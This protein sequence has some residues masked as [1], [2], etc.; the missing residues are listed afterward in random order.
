M[1]FIFAI[2]GAAA[3]VA[4]QASTI[5]PVQVP[6]NTPVQGTAKIAA[7]GVR[8]SPLTT[9]L[10]SDLTKATENLHR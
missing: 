3:L 6:T 1:K 5:S 9:L 4:A 10:H 7:C 2:L 8:R